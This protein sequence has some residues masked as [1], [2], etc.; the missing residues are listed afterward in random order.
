MSLPD[1]VTI[2]TTYSPSYVL[3]NSN[4]YIQLIKKYP[5]TLI[6]MQ[7]MSPRGILFLFGYNMVQVKILQRE[8]GCIIRNDEASNKEL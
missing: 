4:K 6:H 2:N 8:P 7:L 5:L 3:E 1:P